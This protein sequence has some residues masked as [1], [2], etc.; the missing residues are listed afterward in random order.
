MEARLSLESGTPRVQTH[1]M[2]YLKA[3]W[4]CFVAFALKFKKKNLILVTDS[5]LC[6]FHV[7]DTIGLNV[8]EQH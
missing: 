3:Q 6:M 5:K 4:L 8:T 1:S 7:A 2:L